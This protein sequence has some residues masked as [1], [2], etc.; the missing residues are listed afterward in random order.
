MKLDKDE[1]IKIEFRTIVGEHDDIDLL[2]E[3][4]ELKCRDT[5][6]NSFYC[7]ETIN[8]TI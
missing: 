5:A 2:G 7:K 3:A 1:K 6:L 8:F 4:F